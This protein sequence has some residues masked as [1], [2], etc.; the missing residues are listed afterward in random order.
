MSCIRFEE[1]QRTKCNDCPQ[2]A[3]DECERCDAPLCDAC[4]ERCQACAEAAY[5]WFVDAFYGGEVVTVQEQYVQA[6]RQKR[7][8]NG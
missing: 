1:D 7:V 6:W 5:D 3:L 8:S 4:S 2:P